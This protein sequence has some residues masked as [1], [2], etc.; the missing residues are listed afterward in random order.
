MSD[1]AMRSAIKNTWEAAA[2]GWA[3]W[4]EVI[5]TSL[6][7]VTDDLLDMAGIQVGHRV[8]DVACGAGDQTIRAAR[9]VG[10][11]GSV[12]A[13][14]ISGTMLEQVRKNVARAGM[15]NILT[16]ESAAE[17]LTGFEPAF[18]AAISRLGLM[19][20]PGPTAA[21]RAIGNL[22]EP[23]G[24]FAALVFTTPDGNPF[25]ARPMRILLQHA[26]KQP[27]AAGQP[28]IFALGGEGVLEKLLSDAGLGDV[29]T[30]VVC[31]SLNLPSASDALHMIQQAFGA[32]RAVVADLD[33]TA[34]NAAW[35][36]VASSLAD[37]ENHHGFSTQLE[38]IIGSGEKT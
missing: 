22:L 2:P 15:T 31:A 32:Y 19:L 5:S 7:S 34:R 35:L 23:G 11:E 6:K 26:A 30:K 28:G 36:D 1:D 29:R 21:V 25:M 38:F 24:R 3:K 37:M 8:L 9:R 4:E 16:A 17:E 12:V 27:P 18:D 20:F 10:A 14:D 33:E 13:S